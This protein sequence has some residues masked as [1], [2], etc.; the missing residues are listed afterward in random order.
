MDFNRLTDL[1]ADIG[2]LTKLEKLCVS[3]NALTGLPSTFGR[4]QSLTVLKLVK[5]KLSA[6]PDQIGECTSLEEVDLSDNYL[7]VQNPPS[8]DCSM[9]AC[10]HLLSVGAAR[11]WEQIF[12]CCCPV[13][14]AALQ[15][16][17][18][19]QLR[20][21]LM[22]MWLASDQEL[23]ESLG[24]L[25]RLKMLAA[26]QNRIASV[27]PALFKG[28][29][30]LQTLALHENP[31]T[32]EVC[33]STIF[34]VACSRLCCSLLHISDVQTSVALWENCVCILP[35]PGQSMSSVSGARRCWRQQRGMTCWSSGGAASL[36]SR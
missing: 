5:N 12:V 20:T 8:S 27:A 25:S 9:Q 28:C 36:T 18:K 14:A 6:V 1:P 16:H 30:S 32:I 29:T 4:L 3:Q 35:D 17:V 7:Q 33:P 22:A 26:D 13:W 11:V 31:I 21:M 2:T 19:K 34:P 24:S 10:G 23:P 15:L